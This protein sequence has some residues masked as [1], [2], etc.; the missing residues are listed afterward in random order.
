MRKIISYL[1]AVSMVI[2]MVPTAVFA[3]QPADPASDQQPAAVAEDVDYDGQQTPEEGEMTLDE[4]EPQI[5]ED[6]T[7]EGM[8]LQEG[9][10]WQ[11]APDG[12]HWQYY[13]TDTPVIGWKTLG[14]TYYFEDPTG[15][16]MTGWQ[17]IGEYK[18]YFNAT[19][20]GKPG[21]PGVTYGT[22]ATGWQTISGAKYYFNTDGIMQ[23]GWATIG[24]HKYCFS[25]AGKM[26]TGW[27]T[28]GK[29]KYYFG[30]DGI[31][32]TGL[33]TISGFKY[34]FDG[35]GVMK[36]GWV[37]I[38][39]N[40]YYFN[41]NGKMRTG[42]LSE[43]KY[44]YYFADNGTMK[45]GLVK[46]GD[47]R[48]YFDG[49]GRMKTGKLTISGNTYYFDTK[50]GRMKT[51]FVTVG[52]AKY[53]YE[54]SN[55]KLHKGWLKIGSAKYY[56]D[57]SSGKMWTG[58]KKVGK[59]YYFFNTSNG[60]MA[61]GALKYSK[62]LYYFYSN[63][64]RTT[65]KGWFKGSDRKLRYGV[66][67]GKVATGKKTISGITY[68]FNKKTGICEKNLGD[69]YDQ[70]IAKTSSN[71]KY[72][73]Y[74]VKPK[75]Q[76][77]IY[78]GKKKNWTRI[79]TFACALGKP[80]TPTPSGTFTIK[81]KTPHHNYSMN[82]EAVHWN[83]GLNTS[84]NKYGFNGYVWSGVYPDGYIIDSSLGGNTSGGRVRVAENNSVWMY[85]NIPTGTK[86]V[87]K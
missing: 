57:P 21:D 3:A 43:G 19:D 36:T 28:I 75:H 74:V 56:M 73:I 25:S 45:K 78:K 55:G 10:G 70:K 15:Y 82:G 11:Q 69:A 59:S 6:L 50:T 58:M 17:T 1:I 31:M 46:I 34:Y 8:V 41:S 44:K 52:K 4:E 5:Q 14:H 7:D 40:K 68:V 22:M 66:G 29:N 12:V 48:Y 33:K 18:Y 49:N 62:K 83:N 20:D 23:T 81:S 39:S 79:Y 32:Q 16:M 87:I 24:G 67:G 84:G 77:R 30:S 13:L 63:G 64:K 86:V 54:T 51:G 53:Y 71:T 2:T 80:A 9:D 38:G 26:M 27:Q 72:L 76:V 65:C 35:N 42:W 61:T 47:Y 37:T 85:N 60:R